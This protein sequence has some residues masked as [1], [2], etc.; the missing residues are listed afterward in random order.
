MAQ[1]SIKPVVILGVVLACLST[2]SVA[3]ES[4][5]WSIRARSRS[6]LPSS[7]HLT[8]EKILPAQALA[9]KQTIN[10]KPEAPVVLPTDVET[11]FSAIADGG[12]PSYKRDCPR[13]KCSVLRQIALLPKTGI[14]VLPMDQWQAIARPEQ[15][16]VIQSLIAKLN[17]NPSQ[18]QSTQSTKSGRTKGQ[19]RRRSRN[20]TGKKGWNNRVP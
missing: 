16:Y 14:L 4:Q 19:H 17:F 9:Y 18:S 20:L 12:S 11:C 10:L 6:F 15:Q 1:P 3:V 13:E 8:V 7:L 5:M 2:G